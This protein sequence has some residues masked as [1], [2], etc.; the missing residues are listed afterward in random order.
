MYIKLNKSNNLSQMNE[1]TYQTVILNIVRK[2]FCV[3]EFFVLLH[4]ASLYKDKF[5]TKNASVSSIVH[6]GILSSID[7]IWM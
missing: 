4:M 1:I 7:K 2:K 6:K 3:E 5:E